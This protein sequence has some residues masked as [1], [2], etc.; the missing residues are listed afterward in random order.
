MVACRGRCSSACVVI[1]LVFGI[2]LVTRTNFGHATISTAAAAAHYYKYQHSKTNTNTTTKPPTTTTTKNTT[3][4]STTTVATLYNQRNKV[5]SA[6]HKSSSKVRGRQPLRSA[7]LAP[8]KGS[9]AIVSGHNNNNNNKNSNNSSKK[10]NN[11][12]NNK[13]SNNSSKKNN[14]SSNNKNSNSKINNNNSNNKINNNN[15]NSNSS[16]INNNKN[17]NNN[18]SSKINDRIN[19]SKISNNNNSKINDNKNSNN[20]NSNNNNNINNDVN[21]DFSF[22]DQ[23]QYEFVKKINSV[24]AAPNVSLLSAPKHTPKHPTDAQ[25]KHPKDAATQQQQGRN[26]STHAYCHNCTD[27]GFDIHTDVL[28]HLH[29][30]KTGGK[31]FDKHIIYN[32]N[33]QH[34][35][36]CSTWRF[37]H[38]KCIVPATKHVW[39]FSRLTS[40][41]RCGVHPDWTELHECL[42][43]EL[44]RQEQAANSKRTHVKRRYKY[45]TMVREP[46]ERYISEW[47]HTRRG[48][49]WT[50]LHKCNHRLAT[51]R[52]VPPCHKGLTWINVTLDEFL[53]CDSNPAKNRQA[54][55]LADLRLVNCYNTSSIIPGDSKN[56]NGAGSDNSLALKKRNRI[57]LWSAKENLK[58]MAYFGLTDYYKE[59]LDLFEK[60]QNVSFRKKENIKKRRSK[61]IIKVFHKKE[62]D[63]IKQSNLLD[64]QLYDFAKSLFFQ[65]LAAFN[66]TLYPEY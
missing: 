16:K 50:I 65:R 51:R 18:S 43:G 53:K 7:T 33:V 61:D 2:Y 29:I 32:L 3:T 20:I 6:A 28:V 44:N 35:C 8:Q 9:L 40:F 49:D 66:L 15:K 27:T 13:N 14:N 45:M 31:T 19:N 55:M 22:V 17:S 60:M 62:I 11:N 38:C 58:N 37:E 34:P 41:W 5:M 24:E 57:I 23:N 42:P 21:S 64:V 46:V 59:S 30:Q 47:L 10:N 4:T 12:N 63:K 1:L 52:E 48:A 39:L 25:Y 56:G 54:R 36:T 26:A